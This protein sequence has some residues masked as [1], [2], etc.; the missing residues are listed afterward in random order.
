MIIIIFYSCIYINIYIYDIY[1]YMII[2]IYINSYMIIIIF[3]SCIY[4]II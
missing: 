3:Y 2:N 4:I 1:I